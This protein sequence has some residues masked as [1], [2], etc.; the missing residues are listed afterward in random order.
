MRIL[1]G[2]ARSRRL[3]VPR[4][5]TVR[6][7]AARVREALFNILAPLVAGSRFLDVFAGTGSVG[8]EAL[9]RGAG[10]ACFIEANPRVLKVLRANVVRTAPDAAARIIAADALHG[11]CLLASEGKIFDIIYIDPPYGRG[12]EQRALEII[13]SGCLLAPEGVCVV[14]TRKGDI[15]PERVGALVLYRSKRYGDTVLN[16][17]RYEGR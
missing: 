5:T 16:F 13:S 15:P 4:G 6:A 2:S 11:L 3:T 9:S 7:T 14:E 10:E 8:L 12:Y 1:G 17:Y